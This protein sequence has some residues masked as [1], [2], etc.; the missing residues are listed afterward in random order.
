MIQCY[1]YENPGPVSPARP[2]STRG[3]IL[4]LIMQLELVRTYHPQGTNGKILFAGCLIVYSIELPWKENLT[5]VSC[6]PEGRYELTKRWNPRFN[7]HLQVADVPSRECILIHPANDAMQELRG[8]IAPVSMITG[9]GKGIRS[10]MAMDVLVS[11]VY[12]AFDRHDRVFL[13]IKSV[14]YESG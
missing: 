1:S 4:K 14:P 3:A 7:R 9:Q 13:N 10:R 5:Q 12:G 8:C 2:L 6:I 11:L